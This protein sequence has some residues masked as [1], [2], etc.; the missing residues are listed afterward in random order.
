DCADPVISELPEQKKIEGLGGTMRLGAQDV[1]IEPGTL[2]SHLF[3]EPMV[4]QRFRHRY[5]VEP[6]Y[7]ERLSGAGLCFS[8][9]H[10]EQ[11][12]MQIL[13]LPR[14]A[15][16]FFIAA[17]FHPEL[18][19]RPLQPHPMFMGLI[20]ASI[21][22]SNPTLSPEAISSRWLRQAAPTAPAGERPAPAV[23][24]RN[25]HG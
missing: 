6:A 22:R 11:P 23:R 19:S 2:A 20:A 3:D 7:L 13:E 4:R 25:P 17:Q 24:T 18:L 10:P 21:A 15:H 5:E 9:R 12:I 14:D 16:P 1:V 8:G